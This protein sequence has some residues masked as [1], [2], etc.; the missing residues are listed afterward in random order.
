VTAPDDR[1]AETDPDC[2]ARLALSASA[3]H[4]ADTVGRD[5]QGCRARTCSPSRPRVGS[6]RSRDNHLALKGGGLTG[7]SKVQNPAD[8][9][10]FHPWSQCLGARGVLEVGHLLLFWGGHP[11]RVPR[12]TRQR[13]G[14]NAGRRGYGLSADDSLEPFGFPASGSRPPEPHRPASSANNRVPRSR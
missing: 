10:Y 13:R 14:I 5:A 7:E 11:P 6:T 9:P 3:G 12:G 8:P 4:D 1:L 2:R